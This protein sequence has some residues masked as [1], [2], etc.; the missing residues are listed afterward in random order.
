MNGNRLP[1]GTRDCS[2]EVAERLSF[3]GVPSIVSNST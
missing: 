3:G 2:G 1:E